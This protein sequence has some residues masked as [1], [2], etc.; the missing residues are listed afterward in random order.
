[1][2]RTTDEPFD[3]PLPVPAEMAARMTAAKSTLVDLATLTVEACRETLG[4]RWAAIVHPANRAVADYCLSL[5]SV[6]LQFDGVEYWLS[7]FS[8]EKK[9][10]LRAAQHEV[11]EDQF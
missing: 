4:A 9:F 5:P 10:S 7:F 11:A 3:C 6:K 1:M 8:G 2:P